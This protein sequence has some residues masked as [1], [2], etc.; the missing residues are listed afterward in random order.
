VKKSESAR[1]VFPMQCCFCGLAIE[2]IGAD[3]VEFV[4]LLEDDAT[5]HLF[6]HGSCLRKL[7]HP[8]VPTLIGDEDE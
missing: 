8:S 2:R 4:V 1:D 3:P 6:T 5:Q 7:L